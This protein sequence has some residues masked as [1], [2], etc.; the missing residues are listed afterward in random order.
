MNRQTAIFLSMVSF[1]FFAIILYFGAKIT[2]W[3][4]FV[5]SYFISLIILNIL[6]PLSQL[7]SDQPDL[8]LFIYA[9]IQ[10]LGILVLA[11]YIFERSF[12]DSQS[13]KCKKC[14]KLCPLEL[15]SY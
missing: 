12:N 15:N 4:S 3:S 10:L 13:K 9:F 8:T 5:L 6:Y 1:L 11:I 2:A 14:K 7:T